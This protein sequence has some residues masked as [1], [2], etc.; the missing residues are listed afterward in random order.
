MLSS[1][2]YYAALHK[3][4]PFAQYITNS[5]TA[6]LMV[7]GLLILTG[8]ISIHITLTMNITFAL[9][10]LIT[11]VIPWVTNSSYATLC[12]TAALGLLVGLQ[13]SVM[14]GLVNYFPTG[15]VVTAYNSGAGAASVLLVALR[16][17]TRLAAHTDATD[18]TSTAESLLAGVRIFFAV[19]TC[20]CIS[21]LIV[22]NKLSRTPEY[23]HVPRYSDIQL[24]AV[25]EILRDIASPALCLLFCFVGTMMLFPGLF[26]RVPLGMRDTGLDSWFPLIVVALFAVGDTAGRCFLSREVVQTFPSA[27]ISLSLIRF[28]I[29]F[30]HLL[31][32]IGSLPIN[33]LSMYGA[34]FFHGYGNGFLMNMSFVNVPQKTSE[35]KLEAAGKLMFAVMIIGIFS[36]SAIGW[37]LEVFLRRV[38]ST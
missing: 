12:A 3:T 30:L 8:I 28:G 29:L 15:T 7:S 35:A 17:L 6:P 18:E 26:T 2:D 9:L 23:Q 31:Q 37:M 38:M 22:F 27:L 5:Y 36:G 25:P 20:V 19:C 33:K 4:S 34:V 32:W 13:Q 1:L 16:I 14:Y 21:C 10:A 24:S 11:A